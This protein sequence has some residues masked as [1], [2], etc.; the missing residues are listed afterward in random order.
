MTRSTLEFEERQLLV[1]FPADT[2]QVLK[3]DDD[4]LFRGR[5]HRLNGPLTEEGQGI[6]SGTKAVDLVALHRALG[7]HFIEIKDFRGHAAENKHRHERELPLE[8]ALKVRDTIAGLIGANRDAKTD[9]RVMPFAAALVDRRI[10]LRVI[11]WI[12]EDTAPAHPRQRRWRGARDQTR[13][14]ALQSKL[15]W[16]TRSVWVDDPLALAVDLDGVTVAPRP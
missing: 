14:T 5:I 7:L 10:P 12:A 15:A 16:L 6:P 8:I 11:A 4:P 3:W 2:W 13:L 1:R 9:G